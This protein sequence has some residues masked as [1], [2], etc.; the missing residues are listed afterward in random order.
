VSGGEAWDLV[1]KVAAGEVEPLSA[2]ARGKVSHLPG[3]RIPASLAAVVRQAMAFDKTNRYAGVA[4][5]QSDLAA[6][7]NGFA[8]S[9]EKAG[10]AKLL[11]LKV[12]R[13]K[14]AAFATV[15]V[16]L[17]GLGFGARA[18]VEG[19][20]AERG[21]AH[22][23]AALADLKKTAP[24]LLALAASEAGLQHFE[25]ALQKA[26]AAL[27]LDPS[28]AEGYWRRGWVLLAQEKLPEALAAL[29]LAGEKDP[30][31]RAYAALLPLVEAMA[32][33][34]P[35]SRHALE[36]IRPLYEHLTTVGAYGEATPLIPLLKLGNDAR[37]KLVRDRVERWLG[38][39]PAVYFAEGRLWVNLQ[40]VQL[41]SLEALRGLPIDML[42]VDHCGLTSLEPLRGMH[43]RKLTLSNN[44]GIT[45]AAPVADLPLDE[46]NLNGTSI[47]D[48]TPLRGMPLKKLYLSNAI[49]LK[50][51]HALSG[52]PL[53]DLAVT[54]CAVGDFSPLH[55]MPLRKLLLG[56]TR[57]A[58]GRVLRGLPL[59]DLDITSTLIVDL[60]TLAG[61][62]LRSLR[63]RNCPITDYTPLL[64]LPTLE[65]LEVDA[66]MEQLLPLRAHPGLKQIKHRDNSY[67]PI[68]EFWSAYDA[69]QAAGSK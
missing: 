3:G 31:N 58:D 66:P 62:P 63:L 38:K 42:A 15:L 30:G 7:Q 50:D 56:A 69:Q 14:T 19:R 22:A 20:R 9:A 18:L 53:E 28:L 1:Q 25:S 39:V 33:A 59:E 55:G 26:G 21:E 13:H 45:D 52:M 40:E 35:E 61:L 46:L 4:D 60:G 29:Q 12:K 11:L 5:L 54:G 43:L 10:L 36:I 16:L 64:R 17:S 49:K 48:L 51:V 24:D 57:F 47:K 67:R 44:I 23:K 41:G 27:A 68:E 34:S 2:P 65:S 6:F 32:A 8:T 37:L